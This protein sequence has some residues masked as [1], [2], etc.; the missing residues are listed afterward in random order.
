[1]RVTTRRRT[2]RTPEKNWRYE[3]WRHGQLRSMVYA[4]LVWLMSGVR[5]ASLPSVLDDS[6][7]WRTASRTVV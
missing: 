1:M 6:P 3:T 7:S 5:F 4:L 2:T